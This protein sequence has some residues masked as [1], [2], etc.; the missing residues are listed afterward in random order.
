MPS[1]RGVSF[2]PLARFDLIALHDYIA[3]ASGAGVAL[4]YV[5]RVEAACRSLALFPHR[6][7]FHPDLGGGVR[8]L[9]FERRVTIVFRVGDLDVEILRVLYGGR[10]LDGA[11]GAPSP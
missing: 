10:D 3:D 6:G 7:T 5:E 2:R 9:G 4:R 1:E 11:L 8:L